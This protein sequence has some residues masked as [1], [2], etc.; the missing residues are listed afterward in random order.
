M[1]TAVQPAGQ[2]L[3]EAL[4]D[5]RPG[6]QVYA[7]GI[8]WAVYVRLAELRD[9]RRPKM[10]ITFDRGRIELM[11]PRIRHEQPHL[12]L[13]QIVI[14]LAEELDVAVLCG[15]GTT[16]RREDLEQGLEPDNCFYIAHVRLVL[17]L[18]DIVLSVHPPPDLAIETDLTRSSVPKE[19]IYGPLGVPELWR[20]EGDEVT[21]R[22]LQPDRMY[23][24][25]DRSLAF[26]R[27]TSADLSRLLADTRASDEVAAI[28]HYRTWAKSLVSPPANP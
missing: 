12:R 23:R 8:P 21:I 13:G 11:S 4:V 26:P 5:L 1:A 2:W 24:T 7:T 22:Q 17:G 10:K 15:G 19:G 6:E 3:A 14:V 27:V 16:F 9:R 20:H 28:R 18:D 25:A